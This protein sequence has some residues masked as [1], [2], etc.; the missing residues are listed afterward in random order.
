M[1]HRSCIVYTVSILD[2]WAVII[3][4]RI[5]KFNPYLYYY[6]KFTNIHGGLL[7]EKISIINKTELITTSYAENGT[8]TIYLNQLSND[9]LDTFKFLNFAVL[10]MD[11]DEIP[12]I[13]IQY[14]LTG[15]YPYPD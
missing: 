12:E 5:I 2:L 9:G 13:F 11:G 4:H 6:G 8:K 15:Y 14:C 7:S 3:Y 10:D 1:V